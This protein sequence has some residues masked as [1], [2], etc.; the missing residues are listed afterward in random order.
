[1]STIPH[2]SEIL[3]LGCGSGIPIAQYALSRGVSVT[4]VDA[5]P[6][7]IGLA[8]ERTPGGNWHVAD[9]RSIA[10]GR[11][12]GGILAWDS[13]FHLDHAG[14]RAMFGVFARHATE[15]AALLFTA[16]TTHGVAIG[17]L[18]GEPLYHASLDTVEYRRL[19]GA[20]GFEV[21]AHVV[22]DPTCGGRTVWLARLAPAEREIVS[23]GSAT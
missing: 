20:H 9:M 19:L 21:L 10:L 5:S 4:G 6:A 15:S 3:D 13:F 12:F 1:M 8:R 18:E 16:G 22:E 2:G 7:M 14:Q 17:S 23:A 11:V